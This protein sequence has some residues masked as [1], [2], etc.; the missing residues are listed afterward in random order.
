MG[1]KT[2][3]IAF[4]VISLIMGVT[5]TVT[6]AFADEDFSTTANFFG[7]VYGFLQDLKYGDVMDDTSTTSMSDTLSAS[8]I[9]QLQDEVDELSSRLASLENPSKIYTTE[10]LPVTDIDCSNRNMAKAFLSGWCPHPARNIYFIE[11]DRVKEDSIIAISLNQK[12]DAIEGQSIC[13]AINQNKFNFSFEDPESGKVTKLS[14]LH[15]FI[16]KCDQNPLEQDTI[17]TY[18]IINS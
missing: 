12:F 15:G 17:L 2:G 5:T 11:D 13:G 14:D 4:V 8:L 7:M 9:V 10:L 1:H 16:M 3:I 6:V 18:T